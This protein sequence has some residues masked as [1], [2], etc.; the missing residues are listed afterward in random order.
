MVEGKKINIDPLVDVFQAQ[1]G[2]VQSYSGGIGQGKTYGA[3]RRAIKDLLKGRVVYTNWHI[4]LDDFTGDQRKSLPHLIWNT[5]FF[6][7]RFYNID[8]KKNWHYFDLDEQKTWV[9][10]DTKYNDLVDF[11]ANL[12]DCTVYLDEGQDLFDSYEGTKMSKN[13]RKSI[14]RTRHLRKTLV[15]ISQRPQA[16]AVTARA[17]VNV[18]YKHVK[19]MTWPFVHFKVYAT[20][21]IDAQNMPEW[22]LEKDKPVETYFGQKKILNAYNSWYLRKGLKKSQDVHYEAYDLGFI[23][24]LKGIAHLMFPMLHSRH[25]KAT[26]ERYRPA[27]EASKRL[28]VLH[29]DRTDRSLSL[30]RGEGMSEG[31]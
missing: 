4:E 6:R 2:E 5:L 12:T 11:V 26:V 27:G 25:P 7:S 21:E 18:F 3:T 30:R 29:I 24:R 17:N 14:T 19:T 23:D 1:E 8:I 13:K 22:D 31:T 16:I 9:I 20:E 15:V 28:K 10:G